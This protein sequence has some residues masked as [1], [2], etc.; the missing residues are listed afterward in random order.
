MSVG[1]RLLLG[2]APEFANRLHN[3]IT[4]VVIQ[5]FWPS[6][7]K[8][9]NDWMLLTSAAVC[10]LK[11]SWEA[12]SSSWWRSFCDASTMSA[13]NSFTRRACSGHARG[14]FWTI[15][16]LHDSMASSVCSSDRKASFWSVAT[17]KALTWWICF[18]L[19]NISET[20]QLPLNL[21][22]LLWL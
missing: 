15:S 20:S 12:K 10:F 4:T 9:L 7:K 21:Q 13:S 14:L 2:N 8:L 16:A 11:F 17:A 3:I 6:F 18:V 1:I 5:Q 19:V 22:F